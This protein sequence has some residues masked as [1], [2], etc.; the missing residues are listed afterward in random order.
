MFSKR[1]LVLSGSF[2][3]TM[4]RRN[5]VCLIRSFGK[6]DKPFSGLESNRLIRREEFAN[7]MFI[8]HIKPSQKA[9]G[10]LRKGAT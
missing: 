4:L 1:S 5:A 10:C 2:A 3:S 8:N 9:V 6:H 7:L